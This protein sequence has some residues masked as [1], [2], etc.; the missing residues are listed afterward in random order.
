MNNKTQ[1]Q[2]SGIILLNSLVLI[3]F[4]SGCKK[5]PES[6]DTK[7]SRMSEDPLR[8]QVLRY[9]A[10]VEAEI[11]ERSKV[12]QGLPHHDSPID[13]PFLPEA[14]KAVRERLL[15]SLMSTAGSGS[16]RSKPWYENEPYV[17]P[18]SLS[19]PKDYHYK[20]LFPPLECPQFLDSLSD[21]Q[22]E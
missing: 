10:E 6:L 1:S 16:H 13:T 20:P 9:P 19:E 11:K 21:L 5:A 22:K 7:A 4:L 18:N 2:I 14:D 12:S 17:D 3:S 8:S 15:K